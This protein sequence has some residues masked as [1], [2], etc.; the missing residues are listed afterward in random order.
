MNKTKQ[1]N[2]TIT[3]VDKDRLIKLAAESGMTLSTFCRYVLS[4]ARIVK[5]I[6]EGTE[7]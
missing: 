2:I 6:P 7:S 1:I 3:P 5:M 4:K